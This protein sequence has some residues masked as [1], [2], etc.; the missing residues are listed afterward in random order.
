MALK[1]HQVQR[2]QEYH[3]NDLIDSSQS[4]GSAINLV[5]IHGTGFNQLFKHDA[6]VAV[7]PRGYSDV[8]LL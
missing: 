7:F 8:V 2:G 1:D 6:V 5:E 4:A 3:C